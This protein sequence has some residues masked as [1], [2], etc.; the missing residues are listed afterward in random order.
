LCS[1]LTRRIYSFMSLAELKEAVVSL[2]P[3]ERTELRER[4]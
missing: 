4:R 1:G 3:E 2:S